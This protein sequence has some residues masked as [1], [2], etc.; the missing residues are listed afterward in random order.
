MPERTE[1]C[2]ITTIHI[3]STTTPGYTGSL[4]F[5][6]PSFR[7]PLS[8]RQKVCDRILRILSISSVVGSFM[9][10]SVKVCQVSYRLAASIANGSAREKST[11]MFEVFFYLPLVALDLRS[12]LTLVIF[13]VKRD[14]FFQLI[15]EAI[16]LWKTCFPQLQAKTCLLP[17]LKKLTV[18]MVFAT[19]LLVFVRPAVLWSD[20][21]TDPKQNETIW[22]E[23]NLAPI[24]FKVYN[25][26][27][28]AGEFVCRHI[29][30]ILS[31]QSQI[32]AVILCFIVMDIQKEIIR[33][34]S[35]EFTDEHTAL[36]DGSWNLDILQQR[37]DLWT[38]NY[39]AVLNLIK[40]INSHFGLIFIVMYCLDF[41][42]V[43]GYASWLLTANS[44]STLLYCMGALT[45]TLTFGLFATCFAV[46]LIM[47]HERVEKTFESRPKQIL[48]TWPSFDDMSFYALFH[49]V[50]SFQ[51]YCTSWGKTWPAK[52]RKC[53]QWT[54]WV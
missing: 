8:F 5:L 28:I 23:I 42:V 39:V 37:V 36:W 20:T 15:E 26:H 25:W 48:I 30:F 11:S 14:A 41:S 35:I 43:L 52:S 19:V 32:C 21:L 51:S 33:D 6:P 4:A 13:Y 53:R 29:P 22:S 1:T 16:G 2:I 7:R 34:I 47:I 54:V 10:A 27:W 9:F 44:D 18:F 12:F 38:S 3:P 17:R 40:R 49:R 31:Q 50:R 46:P 24:P 45:G